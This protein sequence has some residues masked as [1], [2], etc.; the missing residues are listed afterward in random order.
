MTFLS[1]FVNGL[2]HVASTD[3][4]IKFLIIG[5]VAGFFYLMGH[6]LFKKVG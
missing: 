6:I 5:V 4:G 3:Y 1:H 2:I